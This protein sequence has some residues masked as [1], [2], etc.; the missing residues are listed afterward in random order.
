[1]STATLPRLA[2]LAPV[3]IVDDVETCVAFWTD[4]FGF[5]A[6]NQVPGPDGRLAFASVKRDGIEIMFQSRASVLADESVNGAELA[7]RPTLLFLTV[8]DLDSVEQAV[9]G[10]PVFK[11]RH[12]TFYGSTELYVREPGGTVVG[13]AQF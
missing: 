5:A 8:P 4:R 11:A 9:A 1:M 7:V 12:T 13:F 2:H 10:S 6:E 3:L